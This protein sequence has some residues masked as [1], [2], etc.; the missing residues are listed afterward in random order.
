MPSILRQGEPASLTVERIALE[1]PIPSNKGVSDME[2]Q[3]YIKPEL[4]VLVPV[5][6]LIGVG[7]KKSAL[8]D[9][10]IPLVL[11]IAGVILSAVYVLATGEMANVRDWLLGGFTA[12][13]QGILLAGASVY[14]NQIVKQSK[15]EE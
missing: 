6:Y 9:K 1:G 8:S 2:F 14:V 12:V 10:W 15:K 5:L 7:L 11:G 13:T 3:E 4:L